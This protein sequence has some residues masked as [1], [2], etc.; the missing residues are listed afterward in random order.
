LLSPDA[1]FFC[2]SVLFMDGGTD[3]AARADDWPAPR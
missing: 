1:A 2:G 3:A